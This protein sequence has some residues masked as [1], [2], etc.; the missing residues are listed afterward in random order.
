MTSHWRVCR[1]GC[2]ANPTQETLRKNHGT[3]YEFRLAVINAMAEGVTA[4][5]ALR[6]VME[7]EEEW[8]NAQRRSGGQ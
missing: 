7:Y 4:D 1:A 5:E 3:P 2:G 6:A 8:R